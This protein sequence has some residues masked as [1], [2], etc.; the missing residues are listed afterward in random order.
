MIYFT[1]LENLPT[2]DAKG[3]YLGKLID[4]GIDPSQNA[5][6]VASYLVR[7][8]G[9]NMLCITH[10]QMQS[11]SVRAAQTSVPA[12]H[13]RCY[14]PDEGLLRVKKDV[15]D[16]QIIDVNNRK[17]ERVNDVDLDIEPTDGHTELRLLAVNVGWAAGIRRLLQGIMAKHTIRVISGFATPKTIPW[18]FVN[19]IESDPARR[20]KLRISYDRLAKLHPADVADILEELSR[21]EQKAVIESL[22]EETAADVISEIPTKMQAALLESIQPEKAADIVEEMAPDEAA[23]VLQEMQPEASAVLLADMETEEAH[24][25][26]A[27]LGYEENTAGALMNTEYIVL[28]EMAVVADAVESLKHFEGAIETIHMIHLIGA[29]GVLVGVVPLGRILL[30]D[31]NTPLKELC[32]DPMIAVEARADEKEVVNLF[33]KYNLVSLPVVGDEGRLLGVVTADDVLEVVVHR[34]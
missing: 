2:Y 30:A 5:L 3:E 17:V 28:G 27:L 4:L 13:V 9:K 33:H 20:V 16:Q 15:L 8:P 21:D 22:D 25:V 26:R 24:E 14:A 18:E 29:G 19:L 34:K 1:E 32:T 11:V 10:E 23:D 6:R 7:T 31:A 12:S